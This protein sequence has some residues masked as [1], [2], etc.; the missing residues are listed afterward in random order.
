[1]KHYLRGVQVFSEGLNF[2]RVVEMFTEYAYVFHVVKLSF[3]L[4]MIDIF[5]GGWGFI[6]IIIFFFLGGGR[7]FNHRIT[8]PPLKIKNK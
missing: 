7:F 4:E 5:Q 2:I 8:P 1:M 6:I 3:F